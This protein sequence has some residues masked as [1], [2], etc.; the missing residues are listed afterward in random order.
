MS[1][2]C[3][4]KK[5]MKTKPFVITCT[6]NARIARDV[7]ELRFIKPEGFTFQPGQFVLFD[8]P[9]VDDPSNVETRTLSLCS[10]PDDPELL[11]VMKLKE[12]GRISRWI[13]ETL[14]NGANVIMKGPFGFFLLD[15]T[16][17]K[18]YLFITTGTGV[19]PFRSQ[20]R[21]GLR[22]GERRR[23]DLVFGVR[24]ESDL[25][26]KD[27]FEELAQGHENFFLHL[28]LSNPSGHWHG[29]HGHI[30]TLV[31]IIVQNFSNKSV[32]V[33]GNP[34][35]TWEVKELCLNTWEVPKK[36]LHVEGYL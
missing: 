22:A 5:I 24:N 23:M 1:A 28:A 19:G 16:T 31:P 29:H 34:E 30:Q 7:H 35:M 20:I 3:L 14:K 18:E 25:F 33:C 9:L 26:W 6:Q 27:E 11:F 21:T 15:S 2:V 36:D 4:S 13:I 10:A 12:G 8:I 32:Y 17:P